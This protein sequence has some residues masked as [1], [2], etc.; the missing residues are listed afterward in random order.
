M[1]ETFDVYIF[2]EEEETLFEFHE[3]P[4]EVSVPQE[5]AGQERWTGMVSIN[6]GQD[7]DSE[8]ET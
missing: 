6:F 5:S 2:D 4:A 7:T 1:E 3:P 8:R